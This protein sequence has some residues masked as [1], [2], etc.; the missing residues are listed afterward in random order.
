M[1]YF[2]RRTPITKAEVAPAINGFLVIAWALFWAAQQFVSL[3]A[4]GLSKAL[5]S[6]ALWSGVIA[7]FAIACIAFLILKRATRQIVVRWQLVGMAVAVLAGVLVLA[8]LVA[9]FVVGSDAAHELTVN[10]WAIGKTAILFVLGLAMLGWAVWA[11]IGDIPLPL[12]GGLAAAALI[13]CL[14]SALLA[15]Q[16][17]IWALGIL[18]LA[19]LAGLAWLGARNQG[20][21]GAVAI[22]AAL[23]ASMLLL[24]ATSGA[25][26]WILI[27][28]VAVA[29]ITTYVRFGSEPDDPRW[30]L[31][32]LQYACWI[33]VTIGEAYVVR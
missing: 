3:R 29:W 14:V 20:T 25:V 16:L 30:W 9:Y 12:A 18:A 27:L 19:V 6:I 11:N 33:I 13:T 1:A 5:G 23:I 21:A 10:A 8:V 28:P 32:L 24:N 15:T 7:L 22:V 31:A 2:D 17:P 4:E 26:F